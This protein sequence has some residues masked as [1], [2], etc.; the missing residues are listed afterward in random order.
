MPT[1]LCDHDYQLYLDLVAEW[2]D[3]RGVEVWAVRAYIDNCIGAKLPHWTQGRSTWH[4]R[5][6]CACG[7]GPREPPAAAQAPSAS[8][9]LLLWTS[10]SASGAK[11]KDAP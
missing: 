6:R 7:Y 4:H 3:M 10:R 1:F 8:L 9:R 2:C 11:R 5:C